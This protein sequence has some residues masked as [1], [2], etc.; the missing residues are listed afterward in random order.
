MFE[1]LCEHYRQDLAGRNVDVIGR[2]YIQALQGYS[3][4]TLAETYTEA[5]R[6]VKFFPRLAEL[7][8]IANAGRAE[9]VAELND[10]RKREKARSQP[11]KPEVS[12]T[13]AQKLFGLIRAHI[14]GEGRAERDSGDEGNSG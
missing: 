2:D 11:W 3:L 10:L 7:L 8:D 5:I 14:A 4:E 12:Q 9:A 6:T 13:E 1:R